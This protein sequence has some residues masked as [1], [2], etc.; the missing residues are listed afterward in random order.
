MTVTSTVR[1]ASSLCNGTT[2]L[3]PAGFQFIANGDLIVEL[4]DN[5]SG[6]VTP[7]AEG[8][9]YTISGAG[10]TGTAQILTAT[11]YPS[12]KTLRRRR[13][14]SRQQNADYVPNDGFPAESH[15]TQLDRLT[16]VDQEIGA[17]LDDVSM[18]AIKVPAGAAGPVIDPTD[19][20]GKVFGFDAA[21]VPVPVAVGE[22]NDPG[23]RAD[24]ADTAQGG[25]L[26]KF[27]SRTVSSRLGDTL[28]A[29][30]D[31]TIRAGLGGVTDLSAAIRAVIATLQNGD[32]LVFPK[33]TYRLEAGVANPGLGGGTLTYGVVIN[34]KTNITLD[35]RAATLVS[36]DA[37]NPLFLFGFYNAIDCRVLGGRVSGIYTG[38]T[39]T[40]GLAA[41]Q[42]ACD[43]GGLFGGVAHSCYG[44]AGVF[45]ESLDPAI[46]AYT[47]NR[48]K[49][50]TV[51]GTSR[52]SR[53]GI[54]I[55][56][57]GENL[58]FD[59]DC[60]NVSRWV[61][62]GGGKNIQGRLNGRGGD[63]VAKIRIGLNGGDA[64][65]RVSLSVMADSIADLID[66]AATDESA[67]TI[68]DVRVEG[69][70]NVAATGA[71]I[72]IIDPGLSGTLIENL[73]FS[74]LILRNSAGTSININNNVAVGGVACTMRN[75]KLPRTLVHTSA[76]NIINI[77]NDANA[78]IAGIEIP[79]GF[80][81]TLNNGG[82]VSM[83]G[84]AG[85]R[86]TDLRIGAGTFY[87]AGSSANAIAILNADG[88]RV[89]RVRITGPST[90]KGFSAVG[91]LNVAPYVVDH[92]GRGFT[93]EGAL[94][95]DMDLSGVE[96]VVVTSGSGTVNKFSN[97]VPG[98]RIT[99]SFNG[100]TPTLA[101]GTNLK[102][103]GGANFVATANDSITLHCI[104]PKGNGP[105]GDS[106][107]VQV[108]ASVNA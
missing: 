64:L 67:I 8:A 39:W 28:H 58:L 93:Y 55:V 87:Y 46:A 101:H 32:T 60:D 98:Q 89:G 44:L 75:I 29:T 82:G 74:D 21:G 49:N 25:A 43:G 100:G 2:V 5:L 77:T 17:D 51:H 11:A 48:P 33:G 45:N 91:S 14:T 47:A 23:L 50:I 19:Y 83:F 65:E 62:L 59:I 80:D 90:P 73:D 12:G 108:C 36:Q 15:E 78:V 9:D 57:M 102:L 84:L 35:L 105:L 7:L 22:T 79:D 69:V 96:S 95:D 13:Q 42:G 34:G 107:M 104:D 31:A 40:A 6:A 88:V 53:R 66:I 4:I 61:V 16:L 63:T 41:W 10:R 37:V 3:F 24:L 103:A 72:G 92:L 27:G 76:S 54:N 18:R 30:D 71:A 99:I 106:T 85:G 26:V 86:I 97:V 1:E 52:N 38:S 68:S 70:A 94:T 20:V 81:W 56:A